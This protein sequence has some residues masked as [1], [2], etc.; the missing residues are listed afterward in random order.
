M[1]PDGERPGRRD[2]GE[3]DAKGQAAERGCREGPREVHRGKAPRQK[4]R[5]WARGFAA[6]C[7]VDPC[8]PPRMSAKRGTGQRS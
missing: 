6:S 7:A 8:V 3:V 5:G 4:E 2:V 1:L